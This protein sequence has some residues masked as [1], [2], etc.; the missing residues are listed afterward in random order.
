MAKRLTFKGA[1][2]SKCWH[3]IFG[4]PPKKHWE[5][6]P[7]RI[8]DKNGNAT[9]ERYTCSC[10]KG[11]KETYSRNLSD[12]EWEKWWQEEGHLCA[13]CGE[14]RQLKYERIYY[15]ECQCGAK[16]YL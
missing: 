9:E 1:T 13:Y 7:C 6:R 14:E 5:L 15:L 11:R 8:V 10:E 4:Y 16:G 2:M 3:E 12:P